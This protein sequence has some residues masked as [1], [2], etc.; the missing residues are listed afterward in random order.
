MDVQRSAAPDTQRIFL[1]RHGEVHNPERVLYGRLPGYRLSELG[2][3]MAARSA[4]Y[5]AERV[6]RPHLVVSPLQRARESMAPIEAAFDS[7][8]VVDERVIE[9]WNRFEGT[10]IKTALK[11]PRNWPLVRNPLRPSWGE[12][13]TE[14]AARMLAALRDQA[15]AA[16]GRDVI[17]VSHQLPIWMVHRAV[18]QQPLA[19]HPGRRRCA[20]SSVTTLQYHPATDLAEIDYCEPAAELLVGATDL[21]AV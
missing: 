10:R 9:S 19:H 14:I 2:Q 7:T 18:T 21:G 20:L 12:P 3:Q 16:A 6:E 17:V 1:V 11:D 15:A 5:L 4:E 13:F 8:A